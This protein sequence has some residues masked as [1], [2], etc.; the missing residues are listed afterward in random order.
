MQPT[1]PSGKVTVEA[2]ALTESPELY[3]QKVRL[4][5]LKMLREERKFDSPQDLTAQIE[6]DRNEAMQ[7]FNMA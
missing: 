2:H 3:G 5:L 6:R 4:T 1:M 7:L